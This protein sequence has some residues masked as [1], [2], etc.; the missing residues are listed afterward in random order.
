M[1][2]A[3]IKRGGLALL[4]VLVLAFAVRAVSFGLP[5]APAAVREYYQ[6]E[7]GAPYLSE[8]DSYF[9]VRLSREMAEA[10][11][12]FLYNQREADPLMGSRPAEPQYQPVPVFL[13]VLT[14]WV[15]RIL[16]VFSEVTVLQV[17]RWM[18]PVV[19]SLTAVPAFLY[20]RQRTNLAGC[21]RCCRW[22]G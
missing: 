6:D 7:T 21:W 16:H 14:F 11:K 19:G 8:M 10:G 18:G 3:W 2:A 15:W 9:Y 13:S 4:A 12:S 17:A 22:Y 20:V 5:G 1:K